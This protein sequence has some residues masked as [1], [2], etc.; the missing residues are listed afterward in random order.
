MI[1][2][3]GSEHERTIEMIGR[4]QVNQRNGL[5]PVTCYDCGE[6]F[7]SSGFYV[8]PVCSRCRIIEEL[9]ERARERGE[10]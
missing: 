9:K 6:P 3:S 8:G 10:G 2:T 7:V 1:P 5:S 4:C